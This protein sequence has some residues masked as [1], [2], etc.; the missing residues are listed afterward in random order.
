[1]N[2]QTSMTDEKL[3]QV[4]LSGD[5]NAMTSLVEL[6]K[7]RIYHSVYNIVQDKYIA[8][9][10]FREVFINIINN[11]IAGKIIGEGNFLQWAIHLAQNLCLEYT[12]KNKQAILINANNQEDIVFFVLNPQSNICYY[13]SHGRIKNMIDMLP[14]EQREVIILN[15]YGGLSFKEI[16]GIMKCSMDKALDTMRVGLINLQKQ[17]TAKEMV[18]S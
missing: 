17:M 16:A 18:L 2:Y 6:Y 4:Y 9:D 14:N 15:H 1:M 8:E 3:I 7:D 5:P 10:I 12:R 11:I 13:E